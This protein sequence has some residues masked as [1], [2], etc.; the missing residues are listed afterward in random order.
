MS[1]KIN[2]DKKSSKIKKLPQLEK[3]E[4]THEMNE[5]SISRLI[6]L[7]TKKYNLKDLNINILKG[8]FL[9]LLQE[10]SFE[11]LSEL[12]DKNYIDH[13]GKIYYKYGSLNI[14]Y[15]CLQSAMHNLIDIIQIK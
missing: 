5:N 9:I 7:Y 15:K 13:L 8:L 11:E 4:D 14:N 2:T 6:E 12:N 10:L 3:R 1:S